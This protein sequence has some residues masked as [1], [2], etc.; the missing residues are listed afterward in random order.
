MKED[1]T[2]KVIQMVEQ[3]APQ[4]HLYRYRSIDSRFNDILTKEELM[5]SKGTEFNDPFDCNIEVDTN[6]TENE[7]K[8]YLSSILPCQIPPDV[9]DIL[10]STAFQDMVMFHQLVNESV[11]KVIEKKGIVCFSKINN[12]VLLWSHYSDC[13]KGCVLTFDVLQAPN[14]FLFPLNVIYQSNYPN[15]NHLQNSSDLVTSLIRT[16]S[17]DWEYEAEVRIVKMSPGPY[18]FNKSSLVEIIF[19]WRTSDS[20]I[21]RIQKLTLDNNYSHVVFKRAKL[22]KNQFG[23]DIVPI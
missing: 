2:S 15:Y 22:K 5:F 8:Q 20:E 7:I 10:V 11:R 21:K 14:F 13:H 16:K 23:L 3:G 18:K 1:F 17:L 12:N 6:N 9:I 4:Q 19:G